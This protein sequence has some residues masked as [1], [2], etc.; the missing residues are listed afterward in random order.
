MRGR[1][2]CAGRQGKRGKGELAVIASA[3]KVLGLPKGSCDGCPFEGVYH[4]QMNGGHV[5]ELLDAR[6]LVADEHLPWPVALGREPVAIDVEGLRAFR[7]AKARLDSLRDRQ[8]AAEIEA[9]KNKAKAK[10]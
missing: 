10:K 7:Y 9:A 2:G 5:G 4:P 6:L 1:W 3:E 8:R